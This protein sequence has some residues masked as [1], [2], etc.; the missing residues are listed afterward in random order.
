[1]T[2]HVTLPQTLEQR[3]H[4]AVTMGQ[5]ATPDAMIAAALAALLSTE[6]AMAAE[7][8]SRA[9]AYRQGAS[10][11]TDG[12]DFFAEMERLYPAT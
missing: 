6:D 8:N 10:P 12:E 11:V 4:A 7:M 9:D 3:I 5:Y 1:M 2:L